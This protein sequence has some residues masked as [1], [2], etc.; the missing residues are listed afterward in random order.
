[1]A[2]SADGLTLASGSDD[3]MIKLWGVK[4]RIASRKVLWQKRCRCGLPEC[5]AAMAKSG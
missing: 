3:Q 2:W 5:F 1:V 4:E